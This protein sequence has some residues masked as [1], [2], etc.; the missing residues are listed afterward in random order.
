MKS[1]VPPQPA[2]SHESSLFEIAVVKVQPLLNGASLSVVREPS[3]NALAKK[4]GL[5]REDAAAIV[6]AHKV[7]DDTGITPELLFALSKMGVTLDKTTLATSEPIV[8][9]KNIVA[10]TKL[11][12]VSPDALLSFEGAKS[13]LR[14]LQITDV[15][16]ASLKRTFDLGF[17]DSLIHKLEKKNI[18]TLADLRERGGVK[19]VKGLDVNPDDPGA[20][21]LNA[22]VCLSILGADIPTVTKLIRRGYSSVLDI[23]KTAAHTFSYSLKG[24]IKENEAEELHKKAVLYS[25]Y[26]NNAIAESRVRAYAA[27]KSTGAPATEPRICGCRKCQDAASP[28]A[29]LSDLLNYTLDHLKDNGNSVTLTFLQNRFHQPFRDLP[30]ECEQV[31]KKVRV[32]RIC[33][34][35][36]RKHLPVA[37]ANLIG[38]WYL[39]AAY[40]KLLESNS[41]TYDELR[42]VA[43][44][45][46]QNA[47]DELANR[48]MLPG[49]QY[50]DRLFRDPAAPTGDPLEITEQ[51]LQ[52]TF[53][54]RDSTL[55]PLDP[56]EEQPLILEWKKRFL[57]SQWEA[58][59][60]STVR[61]PLEE[62][63]IIDPDMVGTIDLSNAIP[64]SVSRNNRPKTDWSAFD[65]LEDRASALQNILSDLR[66]QV[67]GPR[68][69]LRQQLNNLLTQLQDPQL[70]F[71]G[72]T[73][74]EGVT[75]RVLLDLRRREQQGD[76]IS[77]ELLALSLAHDEFRALVDVLAAAG[78]G[79]PILNSEWEDFYSVILQRIKLAVLYPQ[80]KQEESA[81]RISF[82]RISF[83]LLLSPDNFRVRPVS[84]DGTTTRWHPLKWRSSEA[85]RRK[86]ESTLRARIDQEQTLEEAVRSSVDSVEEALLVELR[87]DLLR[88]ASLPGLLT[89]S[90]LKWFTD[91][92]QVD[93]EAGR[94]Q[95]TTRVAQAIQTLQGILWGIRSGLLDD[96]AL[97]LN[98]PDFDEEWRW[99]G[100]FA[101][102]RAATQVFIYP[103]NTLR[104]TLRRSMTP[105]FQRLIEALRNSSPVSSSDVQKEISKFE[106]YF[107]EVSSLS[108]SATY[109]STSPFGQRGENV[110]AISRAGGSGQL[111]FSIW[112]HLPGLGLT[113]SPDQT[114]WD[115]IEGLEG[116]KE[117]TGFIPYRSL[118]G[119]THLGIYAKTRDQ[120]NVRYWFADCDGKQCKG[121]ATTSDPPALVR[122]ARYGQEVLS[123]NPEFASRG[124]HAW[125][126]H[127]DDRI[128]AIGSDI[129]LWSGRVESNNTRRIGLAR[130]RSAGLEIV[131][132]IFIQGIWQL[133][134]LDRPAILADGVLIVARSTPQRI[135]LLGVV[136]EQ[137][138][139]RGETSLVTSSSGNW[140]V[141]LSGTRPT[142]FAAANVM[143][144]SGGVRPPKQL[145]VFEYEGEPGDLSAQTYTTVIDVVNGNFIFVLS[146]AIDNQAPIRTE[147]ISDGHGG[148]FYPIVQDHWRIGAVVSP[149]G[150]SGEKEGLVV[151]AKHVYAERRN[152]GD[153]S[154]GRS[155]V[156]ELVLDQSASGGPKLKFG[157]F[158]AI[159]KDG[160]SLGWT[161]RDDQQFTTVKSASGGDAFV[162]TNPSSDEIAVMTIS[163]A[164]HLQLLWS[165]TQS[166]GNGST[167]WSHKGGDRVFS[168]NLYEDRNPQLFF[169][170]STNE[171]M[172]VLLRLPDSSFLVQWTGRRLGSPGESG[173]EGWSPTNASR[174]AVADIDRDGYDEIVALT[175]SDA[176]VVELAIIHAI[177]SV[178]AGSSSTASLRD[179]PLGVSLLTMTPDFSD[180]K[181]IQIQ[182]IY[183]ANQLRD[184]QGNIIRDVSGDPEYVLQN[185]PYLD[186]AYLFLPLEIG[187][188]FREAG[189]YASGLDWLRSV[190]NYNTTLAQRKISYRLVLEE[191][192]PQFIRL[193]DWLLDPLNPHAIAETRKGSYS[194]FTV[195]SIVRC[196]LDY[197]DSEFTR[198]TSESIPRAR[199]L[200]LRVLDLL[201]STEL[202][203]HSPDCSDLIGSLDIKIGNP[204]YEWI[205]HEIGA[206]LETLSRSHELPLI[207]REIKTVFSGKK[208]ELLRYGKAVK[209]IESAIK[210]YRPDT[211]IHA[212]KKRKDAHEEAVQRSLFNKDVLK[213]LERFAESKSTDADV[214]L[215]RVRRINWESLRPIPAPVLSF[216]IPLNP[217]VEGMC[218]HA[219]LCLQKIRACK[220]IAGLDLEV[221]PYGV[222]SASL[223]AGLEFGSGDQL[224]SVA[225]ESFQPL[226]YPYST[227][228]E[229]A[230]QLVTIAGQIEASMLSVIE[231]A[232]R[233][234]YDEL[235]AR[236][237]LG[238]A[239]ASVRLKDLQVSEAEIGV[240][241]AELQM[242]KARQQFNY[243]RTLI[244]NG[245]TTN[246]NLS[247]DAQWSAYAAKQAYAA[248]AIAGKISPKGVITSIL[249]WGG[250]PQDV[251]AA[252]GEAFSALS[253]P[254]STQASYERREQEWNFSAQ[255]ANLDITL[256][257][258]QIA[259]ARNRVF[260]A[261]EERAIANL[262]VD[263]A[264]QVL[265]FLVTKKF[266]TADLYEWMSGILEQV[267]R[268]F[269]RQATQISKLAELQLAFERQEAPRG[270][271]K[272][273]YWEPLSGTSSG[274]QSPPGRQEREVR[275]LTGS[276]RLSRDIYELDQYA[277]TK[278]QRKLQLAETIS[279]ASLD[280]FAFQQFRQRGLL[281]FRT[282][283][284]L[285]DRK[286][287]GHYLRLMRR[288]RLSVV[289]LVPPSQG[290]RAT[291]STTGMS[292]VVI[293]R[294]IFQTV[295]VQKGPEAIALT[296]PLNATGL[297]ELD[298]QPELLV[299][300]EGIGVDTTWSLEMPKASNPFDFS[301]IAD[302][303]VTFEYTALQSYDYRQE[304]LNR[305]DQR[306]EADRS[307]SFRSDFADA[308][309]DLNNPD[310]VD[311]AKQMI[312]SFE[313]RRTDFPPNL[314]AGASIRQLV[315]Y[316]VQADGTYSPV[317]VTK[318]VFTPKGGNQ[319]PP[320]PV[321]NAMRTIS[322]IEGVISTRRGQ[323]LSLIGASADGTWELTLPNTAAMKDR[324]K[325]E[326]IQ[327]ILLVIT[328]S[329]QLAEWPN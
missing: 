283:M 157:S 108:R 13:V 299:P 136:N 155:W 181:R 242:V 37:T 119:K 73:G 78:V 173:A 98:A 87:N 174:Y 319:I 137:L 233:A 92:Y 17:S 251:F 301:T 197:A 329:G 146:Q 145:I 24:N 127:R 149:S 218:K 44:G 196:L 163:S 148:F 124:G 267:Y 213:V 58:E 161:W 81:T 271:I 85:I 10:A 246:E 134:S 49:G 99:L 133:S 211:I 107:A 12:I 97:V 105:A 45:R 50:V 328:Y 69:Q 212:L 210:K 270:I 321:G 308:W 61:R 303:L 228:V 68:S 16:L 273:D 248:A 275:G 249:Q 199:E 189:D 23:G 106:E 169:I 296:A 302:V 287:P 172:G 60:Y 290:I 116:A 171:L 326:Q 239:Q 185:L 188:R 91:H 153:P 204:E 104:P 118:D 315:L 57:R 22:H 167:G 4:A 35:I 222:S 27:H 55:G 281:L 193:Q 274:N 52:H 56:D 112:K 234:R 120:A 266:A 164:G 305:L 253:S 158:D 1:Q 135:A 226:P 77:S 225:T 252:Q 175:V 317:T 224:P 214:S 30:F 122:S 165:G 178:L 11:S 62:Y 151:I 125:L 159:S 257:A 114:F 277:F 59:D 75:Y 241:S 295:Q 25:N 43:R 115:R 285:F 128:I 93:F 292:R 243:Y 297:F 67:S 80:W 279:L 216:C 307:F 264:E 254:L 39:E 100:S 288:V 202:T 177:P 8:L 33:I 250:T 309:Y 143:G 141:R 47:K 123:P 94:C 41:I 262:Q 256:G 298:A 65:F 130:A 313:T 102:R 324:F 306:I 272:L 46:N 282:P 219:E 310:L 259:Q 7:A 40:L 195:L 15:S 42:T 208:H 191:G 36:L 232:N 154:Q 268:F 101:A 129:L 70:F 192:T 300:F 2:I 327:D 312:V 245:L 318:V 9:L 31:E 203:Q 48:M 84:R 34:E 21:L 144:W 74:M 170:A 247:L 187:I 66:A 215:S 238:L 63:P 291:L 261:A 29:Y 90:K 190:Y 156:G 221:E 194:K 209:I 322:S 182:Q 51:W 82:G 314:N 198:A 227:L 89:P 109:E 86:W 244:R 265:N 217:V 140:T 278:N 207:M 160:G 293:G 110:L 54:L 220:N 131:A 236:Q 260:V 162:V 83:P 168:L 263:H 18:H 316:F 103:E 121:Q 3:L 235:K 176:G 311:P 231:S 229:R 269:L 186:E 286:F 96:P 320:D 294:D 147:I 113:G 184:G 152:Y 258:Q 289:A 323:W 240:F 201:A 200:Y 179:G 71:V 255:L 276:A 72:V 95:V 126:F 26:I 230:K 183:A 142:T 166:S 132:D 5:T 180:E 206:L 38:G 20:K 53:G 6:Q 111:Y 237:D 223:S 138:V 88:I 14:R 150:I 117:I 76:E 205:R 79:D 304:V 139:V 28:L 32:A 19:G 64:N 280:P 325:Q 284:T